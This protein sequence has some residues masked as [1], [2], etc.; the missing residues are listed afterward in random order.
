MMRLLACLVAIVLG[1]AVLLLA[2]GAQMDPAGSAFAM[3][4]SLVWTTVGPHLLV[5]ALLSVTLASLGLRQGPRRIGLAAVVIATVAAIGSGWIVGRIAVATRGAGGSLDPVAAFLLTTMREPAPDVIETIAT[6][7]GRDL[8]AAIYRTAVGG[9]GPG[10]MLVYI[11][12]GGFM[13]G[14]ITETAA[15]LR[16][17][18]DRGWLAVSVDYRVFAPGEPTWDKATPDTAC[19]LAWAAAHAARLGGDASRL[20][21]M[22]DSAGGN[23]AI[24]VGYGAGTGKIA[25][26][27][28]GAVPVPR[29]IAV[30]YPAVDPVAIYERGYPIPGF[31]PAMLMTGYVGGRP[32]QFPD[33]VAAISS[34]TY[35]HPGA[36][37]TLIIAPDKDSLVV[38]DSVRAF[39]ETARAAGVEVELVRMPYANHIF[40]QIAANS[41]GNQAS[42]TI[43][44]RFME[45][46]VR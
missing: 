37:K 2:A 12:G 17:F 46:A 19:G 32:E 1:T 42:R 39:A 28:G 38:S 36:P 18:A 9:P 45:Q 16:W 34:A 7:E 6:V 14:T 35:V 4:G 23:L 22:G 43:R 21:L 20:V 33:R 5:V 41:L 15:D 30:Q 11:H 24:N 10:P 3:I 26:G 40:N 27:C 13:A 25:S 44:L 8:K 31:E 29:A